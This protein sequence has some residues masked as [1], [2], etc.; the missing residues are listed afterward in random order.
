MNAHH[1]KRDNSGEEHTTYHHIITLD[2]G[3]EM[4]EVEAGG[5]KQEDE[6]EL[7]T[8]P[9]LSLHHNQTCTADH[10]PS[11]ALPCLAWHSQRFLLGPLTIPAP[12]LHIGSCRGLKL[13]TSS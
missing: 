11:Q 12:Q 13:P 9:A 7:A 10:Q 8:L 4:E 1:P 6:E 5:A 2:K 3:R